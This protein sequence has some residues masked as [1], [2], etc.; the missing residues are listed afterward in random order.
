MHGQTTRSTLTGTVTDP[1]GAGVEGAT[2]PDERRTTVA[3]RQNQRLGLYRSPRSLPRSMLDVERDGSSV[4]AI[5]LTRDRGGAPWIA[6]R[7]RGREEVK[8]RR[9]RE[10]P[11]TRPTG[12]DRRR[13]ISR[14][15][16]GRLLS[17]AH[18]R[19]LEAVAADSTTSPKIR[20]RRRAQRLPTAT[21]FL[22]REQLP[23][24]ARPRHALN[25]FVTSAAV[26]RSRNSRC[27]RTTH[28]GIRRVRRPVVNLSTVRHHL[29]RSVFETTR[30][31]VNRA[32]FFGGTQAPFNSHQFAARSAGRSPHRM[33]FFRLSAAD[34]IGTPVVP[35]ATAE[36]RRGICAR[37]VKPLRIL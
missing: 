8:V 18:T 10:V 37:S 23:A 11:R 32:H 20:R 21:A 14:S 9:R 36:M 1:A 17:A 29:Q 33:F 13:A 22:G 16:H 35:R 31:V 26:K 12:S 6:P 28:L 15:A 4:R 30:L 25:A 24:A 19:R 7:S 2:P 3:A 5:G 27:R 34:M